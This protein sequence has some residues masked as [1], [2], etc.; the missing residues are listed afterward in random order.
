MRG[1]K[2]SR[3]LFSLGIVFLVFDCFCFDFDFVFVF[4]FVFVEFLC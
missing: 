1:E 2:Q 4:L 3:E